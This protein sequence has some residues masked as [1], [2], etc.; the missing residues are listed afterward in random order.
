MIPIGASDLRQ[1]AGMLS[2]HDGMFSADDLVNYGKTVIVKPGAVTEEGRVMTGADVQRLLGPTFSVFPMAVGYGPSVDQALSVFGNEAV[3]DEIT[4]LEKELDDMGG[5]EGVSGGDLPED[6]RDI[7]SGGGDSVGR[8]HEGPGLHRS[9]RLE[10]KYLKALAKFAKCQTL[11]DAGRGRLPVGKMLLNPLTPFTWVTHLSKNRRIQDRAKMCDRLHDRLRKIRTKMANKG[12]D[13]SRLP[14]IDD[15]RRSMVQE[16]HARQRPAGGASPQVVYIER[17]GPGYQ[18]PGY[19]P[20]SQAYLRDQAELE[21][22]MADQMPGYG[23]DGYGAG[24]QP[25]AGSIELASMREYWDRIGEAVK[26]ALDEDD[27]DPLSA[28]DDLLRDLRAETTGWL[29]SSVEHDYFGLEGT[30]FD[31]QYGDDSG[32]IGEDETGEDEGVGADADILGEDEVGV[33]ASGRGRNSLPED[34]EDLLDARMTLVDAGE[35]DDLLLGP[36]GSVSGEDETGSDDETGADADILGASDVELSG[37]T[38]E[39]TSVSD[40]A[41]MESDDL[42][43]LGGEGAE[44]VGDAGEA[45]VGLRRLVTPD[46]RI[47]FDE[48][49]LGGEDETGADEVGA[50]RP[51]SKGKQLELARRRR[52]LRHAIRRAIRHGA[53]D[54]RI[55]ALEHQLAMTHRRLRVASPTRGVDWSRVRP[56]H[57]GRRFGADA[58]DPVVVIAIRKRPTAGETAAMGRDATIRE[59]TATVGYNPSDTHILD[60]A[61]ARLVAHG[62]TPVEAM[63]AMRQA[64]IPGDWVRG[65][66]AAFPAGDD[67]PMVGPRRVGREVNG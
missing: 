61:A 10:A 46:G 22:E 36:E 11:L 8:R 50:H 32:L 43:V 28:A 35:D 62:H 34:D 60:V 9:V 26:E 24:D 53:P 3:E 27:E 13:V 4:M 59:I 48:I 67:A 7:I 55:R 39:E 29:G 5:D 64:T 21:R 56:H 65:S 63:S 16:W 2:G 6:D 54:A 41:L 17:Q 51:I 49:Q 1:I 40:D 12:I 58:K 20:V 25:V 47:L 66:R 18:R 45:T 33:A 19:Q 38:S 37:G 15:V 52:H 14:R 57:G 23:V 44:D 30:E 42:D 31:S